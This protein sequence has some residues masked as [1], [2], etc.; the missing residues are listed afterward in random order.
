MLVNVWLDWISHDFSS[1]IPIVMFSD[2]RPG[3]MYH[4]AIRLDDSIFIVMESKFA[5][6][7]IGEIEMPQVIH[8][9]SQ[10]PH[11]THDRMK[12]WAYSKRN[13][14][15]AKEIAGCFSSLRKQKL[16]SS[17]SFIVWMITLS[18][19][20][21][22]RSGLNREIPL[23]KRFSFTKSFP[24]ESFHCTNRKLSYSLESRPLICQAI[25]T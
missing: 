23:R 20:L 8:E 10:M 4:F 12:R 19:W 15:V 17:N 21:S 24:K 9:C 1:N 22:Q 11:V 6:K 25:Q 2:F 13:K 7:L 3:K 18:C 5:M 16:N 14:I